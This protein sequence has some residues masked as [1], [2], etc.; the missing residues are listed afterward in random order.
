MPLAGAQ[1]L[2]PGVR[3]QMS[4]DLA[5]AF[6]AQGVASV[7]IAPGSTAQSEVV[8]S[9]L[10]AGS[11]T[12][13]TIAV[14]LDDADSLRRT[15]QTLDVG[16]APFRPSLGLLA[17]DV[18]GPGGINVIAADVSAGVQAAGLLPGDRI[19]AVNGKKMDGVAALNGVLQTVGAKDP[20]S[21]EVMHQTTA[22]EGR[23]HA[24]GAAACHQSRR[25][26]A[27]LQP[28]A[29]PSPAQAGLRARIPRPKRCSA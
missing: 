15:I 16:F 23:P 19:V 25:P 1:K 5:R 9:L 2:T 3:V 27:A 6:E 7:T 24:A 29:R 18:S 13:D 8:L 22:E 17:V 12:P 26:V 14:R 21:L 28:A 20:V 4:S 11:S 10:A